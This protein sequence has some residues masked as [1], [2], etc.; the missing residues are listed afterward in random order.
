MSLGASNIDPSTHPL[1]GALTCA[2]D[3]WTATSLTYAFA[4]AGGF[5]GY[6]A[7]M[8][9][10]SN[11]WSDSQKTLAR[12]AFAEISSFTTL[13]FS[14]VADTA[15][16]DILLHSLKFPGGSDP[17]YAY[18]ELSAHQSTVV[19]GTGT[20][21]EHDF[22]VVHAIGHAVGLTHPRSSRALSDMFPRLDTRMSYFNSNE[23]KDIYFPSYTPNIDVNHYG[24]LDIAA[25]QAIYGAN[26]SYRTGKDSYG[27]TSEIRAIWDAGGVDAIDFSAST[28]GTIIDLRA[29]S[30]LVEEGGG[31]WAS[32]APNPTLD[33]LTVY[34][35]A[36]G[37]VIENGYGG[38]GADKITGNN[39]TNTLKGAAGDD[40]LFGLDGDDILNGGLGADRLDGGAGSDRASYADAA[41]RVIADLGNSALNTGEAAGDVYISIENL[42]GSGFADDLRGDAGAN[43]IWGG[44]GNDILRGRAGNDVLYGQDGNDILNGGLGADRLD[45]GA[46]SDRASY[47]DAAVRVIADLGNSAFNTGEAA[48]DTYVSI[49]NLQGSGFADDLRGDAGANIIWG[50]L[51]N[52]IL[53]GRA[54]DDVLYGQDGTDILNGGLGADR[55]DGGAGSDRAS[56]ADAAVRVIADLGNSALNT[57]EAAGD[58]YV[59]IEN[60]QGS[61]FADDL[62]GDA[63]ANIIWGGLGNDILRGRAGN[64]V[65]YGQDGNDVLNGGLG[66]D[67]L[68]GGAGSDR[69]TYA[70]A[71]VGLTAD[72]GNSAFNTGE[73]AGDTYVSIEN[74]QGSNFADDLRGDAGDNIIWGGGG[75]DT[76]E[77]GHGRDVLYGGSGSD[78]FVFRSALDS[79]A[80]TATADVIGDFTRGQDLI[81]FS[82]FDADPSVAGRQGFTGLIA[83]NAAFTTAGQLRF[84]AATGTLYGNTDSDG[85][86]E[87]AIRLEGVT[88]L[89]DSDFLF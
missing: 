15:A 89:A 76:L 14:E 64:D 45:G 44:L 34:T 32:Y 57:G 37:V 35:I 31:G 72:L 27:L 24:A 10:K 68:D 30:L 51:G 63:G 33:I 84:D 74:L 71:A 47:A 61:G 26:S 60:L 62:R 80:T 16:S 83:A 8:S 7:H 19:I 1:L 41:V 13:T 49:E 54:G 28:F 42:Q 12:D 78:L 85:A 82:A 29:A 23:E 75:N 50:G 73:A 11:A 56:Y 4:P 70:N 6:Y 2:S 59:S 48:G 65:L 39:F 79:G 88:A 38:S 81:D 55:L 17:G 52:D 43:I 9:S 36:Y 69:V 18:R 22:T 87:F 46:G 77:G 21:T 53:R 20:L 66:A 58:T 40:E 86:A 5:Y 67:R 3:K 25:L